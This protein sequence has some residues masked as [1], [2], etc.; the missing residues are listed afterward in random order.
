V[1]DQGPGIPLEQAERIFQPDI[2]LEDS[3]TPASAEGRGFGLHIAKGIVEA[4]GGRIWVESPACGGARFCVHMP[5]T[6]KEEPA[7]PDQAED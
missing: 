1:I 5:L 3:A 7:T 4:H 6:A 2:R